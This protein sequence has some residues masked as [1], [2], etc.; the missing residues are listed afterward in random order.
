MIYL[1][2]S[3]ITAMVSHNA[4]P[5]ASHRGGGGRHARHARQRRDPIAR[6]QPYAR[7]Y[8]ARG[9]HAF[10]RCAP[11]RQSQSQRRPERN[12]LSIWCPGP[13]SG[14]RIWQRRRG[15]DGLYLVAPKAARC[16]EGGALTA[17]PPLPGPPFSAPLAVF[18]ACTV[19][20]TCC[21]CHGGNSSRRRR[22]CPGSC[23]LTP[24]GQGEPGVESRRGEHEH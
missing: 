15:R 10:L 19:A 2:K 11:P 21:H 9:A 23:P 24:T 16:Q 6:V 13:G 4:V 17:T 7:L 20:V 22:H 5:Y 18:F 12:E 3:K 8:T 1:T 14:S